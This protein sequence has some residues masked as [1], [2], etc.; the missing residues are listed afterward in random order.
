[1]S[2]PC[3]VVRFAIE[4]NH[5]APPLCGPSQFLLSFILANV[6]PGG[7]LNALATSTARVDTHSAVSH[8]FT[9]RTTG[10]SSLSVSVGPA[11]CFRRWVF[12]DLYA[13]HKTPPE[14]P[15]APTPRMLAPE[16]ADAY[17]PD[18]RHCISSPG[19]EVV[20]TRGP[21]PPR[22]VLR[23]VSPIAEIPHCCLRKELAW[24]RPQCG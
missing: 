18:F 15:S 20:M 13:F 11:E 2:S 5:I 6:L 22:A 19:K 4:L 7:I 21:S 3:K 8:T 17:S 9:A 14:I 23:Q 1:M 10:L 12:F 24:S 16:L